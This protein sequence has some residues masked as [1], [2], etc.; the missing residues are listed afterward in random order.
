MEAARASSARWL[1]LVAVTGIVLYLCWLML[2]PFVDVLLWGTVLAIV[3]WPVHVRLRRRGFSEHVS[4]LLTTALTV[5]VVLIPLTLITTAVLRQGAVAADHLQGGVRRLLDPNSRVFTWLD[6]H[7][8]LTPLRDPKL[9]G[10][11]L[12]GVWGAV[13]NRT[14]GLVGGFIGGVVQ[15]FFVLFTLYYLL[16]DA[17]AII[18]PGIR[19]SIPLTRPQADVIFERTGEVISASVNGVLVIS[20]I[21]GL[22]G[23]LAFWVLGLPSALL[24]G[25]IMF[26]LSTI[27]MA[28]SAIVWAPAAIYLFVTGHWIKGTLLVAWGIL[29]IG[30]IDN[31]LRPRLVGKRAKLHELIIFFSVLGGLQVFGVLG[32]FVGPVVAAI[33]LALIE[34][35]RRSENVEAGSEKEEERQTKISAPPVIVDSTGVQSPEVALSVP[36]RSDG[37]D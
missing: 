2:A 1:A 30:M 36:S 26:L 23:M 24:W 33:A 3:V 6:Q 22:L 20:A 29:V 13:A 16:R 27:P 10:S 32:L 18:I 9:L 37:S 7:F 14:L 19:R 34:V 5:L 28:G 21:Q 35:F 11:R 12:G 25:V 4:A 31:V 17:E 8:D 15:V